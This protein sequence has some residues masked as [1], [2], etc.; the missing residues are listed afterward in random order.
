[1]WW[2]FSSDMAAAAFQ[3][4]RVIALRLMK[5]AEGGP[6]AEQEARKM[7]NEKM[8]AS[9][10]AATNLAA[11]GSPESVLRRYRTIMRANE[12]RLSAPKRKK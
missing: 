5:L 11:G 4:Q 12:K 1:M 3:A 8:V 9:V 10:E 6:G 2:T 7:V